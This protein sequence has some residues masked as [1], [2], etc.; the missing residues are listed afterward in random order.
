MSSVV[1]LMAAIG[2]RQINNYWFDDGIHEGEASMQFLEAYDLKATAAGLMIWGRP[3]GCSRKKCGAV[4][5]SSGLDARQLRPHERFS[6]RVIPGTTGACTAL[7]FSHLRHVDDGDRLAIALS[8]PSRVWGVAAIG[9]SGASQAAFHGVR[10]RCR[11]RGGLA[12]LLEFV[13]SGAAR[14]YGGKP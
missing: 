1:K 14:I 11:L 12:A 13:G 4:R 9:A 8:R 2:V 5:T 10:A 3:A 6:C 7:E